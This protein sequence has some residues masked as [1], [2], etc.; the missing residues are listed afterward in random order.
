MKTAILGILVGLLLLDPALAEND[1]DIF[2]ESHLIVDDFLAYGS[3]FIGKDV[4]VSVS[5]TIPE[6]VTNI[7]GDWDNIGIVDDIILTKN[8]QVHAAI[9]DVGGFLGIG[10][11][12]I[13]LKMDAL[14]IV[15]MYNIDDFYIVIASTQDQ[16]DAAPEYVHHETLGRPFSRSI[17]P[18]RPYGRPDIHPLAGYEPLESSVISADD[19]KGANVYG[20]NHQNIARVSEVLITPDGTVEHV[21][22]DV[23]GFLGI[24]SHSVAFDID[25]LDLHQGQLDLRI[26]LSMTEEEIRK[27]PEYSE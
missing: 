9:I 22:I 11:R 18:V 16:I 3:N 17:Y 13:A 10:T 12:T 14:H 27:M 24:G 2:V 19:L 25:E 8:G 4:F 26:Y 15:D 7:P 20:A 5:D 23:G 6:S 1:N 21:I